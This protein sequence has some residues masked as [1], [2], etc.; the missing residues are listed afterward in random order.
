MRWA[1]PG[2]LKR[3]GVLAINRRNAHYTQFLNPR[4]QYPLV[5]DKLA[6]KRLVMD[7]GISVPELYGLVEAPYQA[8]NLDQILQEREN[9]VIKPARGSGG[10]GI[11]V[12][13][14]RYKRAYRLSNGHLMEAEELRHHV[15]DILGG[16]F[17]L[18]GQPDKAFVEE[19]VNFDLVFEAVSYQGVPDV[20]II[21][22][23]AVPVMAMVRLPTRGSDGKANLH[24]GAVG[25]GVDMATGKTL[26]GVLG[27]APVAEHPDTGHPIVGLQVPH[28][29]MLL[30]LAARCG[31]LTGMGYLGVDL[32]LDRIK[33]PLLLELNARPGLNIQIANGAGLLPRLEEV[34][35]ER[36][37]L[38]EVEDRVRFSMERFAAL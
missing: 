12:F 28:W 22:F 6:T 26:G 20:R 2:A 11:L 37:R 7:S 31:D 29:E 4:K 9:F 13:S 23:M 19:K 3:G 21:V 16:L 25:V 18:G 35:R 24:K 30:S 33:G 15:L 14:G 34:R 36:C 17:S 10:K 1:L 38:R 8:R 32:V 5:D 27:N